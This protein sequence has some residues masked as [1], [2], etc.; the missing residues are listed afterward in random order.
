MHDICKTSAARGKAAHRGHTSG[1]S[2]SS[3]T[4]ASFY[5]STAITALLHSSMSNVPSLISDSS[6]VS[7][8]SSIAASLTPL[9]GAQAPSSHDVDLPIPPPA[10]I[11]PNTVIAHPPDAAARPPSL[12]MVDERT[13]QAPSAPPSVTAINT[14]SNPQSKKSAKSTSTSKHY[15]DALDDGEEAHS[16]TVHSSFI[17]TD[18][19]SPLPLKI[20]MQ[21]Q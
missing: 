12:T 13:P 14:S 3:K 16:A 6:A 10:A 19:P 5:S 1:L 9:T 4:T 8:A 20:Q 11:P 2:S 17:S 7:Q 18:I 21:L 15:W